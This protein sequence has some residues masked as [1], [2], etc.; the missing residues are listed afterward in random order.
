MIYAIIQMFTENWRSL[1]S[2]LSGTILI[3]V[4]RIERRRL[5]T[6]PEQIKKSGGT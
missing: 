5:A 3:Q 2:Q 4:K 1:R 6:N